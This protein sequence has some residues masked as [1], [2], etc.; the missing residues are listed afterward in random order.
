MKKVDEKKIR[1]IE[2]ILRQNPKGLW[3]REISRKTGLD[4]STVSI[5]LNK[6]LKQ[7]ITVKKLGNLNLIQLKNGI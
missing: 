3:V 1:K 2:K 7:K 5:Y 6:H 4:K